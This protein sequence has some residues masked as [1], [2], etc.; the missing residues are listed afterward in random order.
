VD[1]PDRDGPCRRIARPGKKNTSYIDLA[2]S[3][4]VSPSWPCNP[5]GPVFLPLDIDDNNGCAGALVSM[6]APASNH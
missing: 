4:G 2:A 6:I 1:R 3:I 5:Y